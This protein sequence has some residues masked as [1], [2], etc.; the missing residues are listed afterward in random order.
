MRGWKPS[1]PSYCAAHDPDRPSVVLPIASIA[2]PARDPGIP[3]F[4]ETRLI[5]ILEG[6]R[7]GDAMRPITIHEL[8]DRSFFRYAVCDGFHR[9]YASAAVGFTHLPVTICP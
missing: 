3:E 9:F 4:R 8:P 5:R 1:T 7:R 6:F 2:P